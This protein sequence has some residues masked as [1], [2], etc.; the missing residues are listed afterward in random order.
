M[1]TVFD[2]TTEKLSSGCE[3]SNIQATSASDTFMAGT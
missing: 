3:K 1:Q 2:K